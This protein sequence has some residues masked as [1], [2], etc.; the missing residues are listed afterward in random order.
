MAMQTTA[1]PS[2]S[3]MLS[4]A[5][6]TV[7]LAL[8]LVFGSA[9]FM[10]VTMPIEDLARMMGWPGDAPS[11]LVR[12]IGV[13]EVAGALGLVFPTALRIMPVLTPLAAGGLTVIMIL[14][15]GLHT[16]RGEF[17]ILPINVI[18]A[19]MALFVIWGRLSRD[20]ARA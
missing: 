8:A 9:G 10:K 1:Q 16:V 7:Q 4:L 15:I 18:L 19:V 17:G 2:T 14:A 6:W 11:I 20:P 3:K 5:L 13:S 12:F